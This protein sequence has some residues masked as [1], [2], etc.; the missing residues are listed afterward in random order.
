MSDLT[1]Y[2][3]WSQEVYSIA[4]YLNG[5][6]FASSASPV[7]TYT[8]EDDVTL[9]SVSD[10]S[11]NDYT[12]IGWYESSTFAG[13]SVS[14]WEKGEI[15]GNKEFYARWVENSGVSP[16]YPEE[17]DGDLTISS[18]S[19]TGGTLSFSATYTSSLSSTSIVVQWILDGELLSGADSLT[20]SQTVTLSPGYHSIVVVV[21]D[22]GE[23]FSA[24]QVFQVQN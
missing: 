19:Y 12:F 23:Q 22:N 9:P 20:G 14:G 24:D 21:T 10:I 1:I 2:A 16:A 3:K 18:V 4:Y 5:G 8:I 6:S 7:T 17:S 15:T 11:R 13:V